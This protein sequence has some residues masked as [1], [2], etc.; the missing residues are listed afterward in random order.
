[1]P[2]TDRPADPT[3]ALPQDSRPRLALSGERPLAV[4]GAE[5]VALPVVPGEGD[6]A[7]PLLGPGAEEVTEQLGIDLLALLESGRATGRAGQVVAY[8]VPLGTPERPALRR[9]LLVGVGD[10]RP[11]D[12]RKAGA[13]LARAVVG[14]TGTT[15]G[16][17]VA[18]SV[19]ALDPETGLEPFAV[20]FVLGSF[21]FSWRSAAPE[22]VPAEQLVLAALDPA[23][24][25]GALARARAVAG[26]GWRSRTLATVPS[27]LK[28]PVWLAEEARRV[29]DEAGLGFRVWD[30][31]QLAAEGFG[32]ILGVGQASATPPRLVQLDYAPRR[33]GRKVPT[34]VLV[35]KGIT[36]D[37][38]GLSI[39][40]A[41]AMTNMKRDMTG[42][43][44]VLATMAALADVGCPVRVVG[45]VPMAE[46][47]VSGNALR[48][49][50]VVRH[51]GGRT[52]EITNTDA[53]GRV[54]M[55]DALA[56]AVAELGPA[57]VVDV[58][59]LTGAMKVALGQQVGGFFANRETLAAAIAAAGDAA[60]EPLWRMPLAAVYEDKLASKVADADNGAGGPGAITA[61]LFLQ[62][63]VGDVPWAHLDVA[64]VGDAPAD[65][66]EWTEGPTG[67]GARALL[68][69]LGGDAPLDGIG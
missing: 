26:A 61:A 66:D 60:G 1:M 57:V 23:A 42:G 16:V 24:Y 40:P 5:V 8:P 30:E 53:E 12:F 69:W 44:V 11:A 68:A 10:Q 34:V 31:K 17:T 48:P 33:A 52:T 22:R 51:W 32:G 64:S 9:V 45:L 28:N 56:Y 59:T 20:G 63:F 50:D 27:N 15:T 49:G 21:G 29:A 13:A 65:M 7:A 55:A 41:Q 19:P 43:A 4:D 3:T 58:A 54:V 14:T 38:G 6:D 67:F 47:A 25:D 2:P 46:N 37:T 39:K 62:H 18:T 36:F 35:G